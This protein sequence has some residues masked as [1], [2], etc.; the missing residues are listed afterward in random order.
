[1]GGCSGRVQWNL[2]S[3][4]GLRRIGWVVKSVFSQYGD[5]V[6][7]YA[8]AEHPRV[9][10]HVA[11]TIDDGLCRQAHDRSLVAEVR[12][13]LKQHKATATFF[14]CSDYLVGLEDAARGL[15]EDGNELANHCPEDRE[16]ASMPPGEF[17]EALLRTTQ[18][19]E[20]IPG[21]TARWFRAPQARLTTTM[22]AAVVRS[23]LRHALGDCYCDDWAIE[24]PWYIAS[25][26]AAQADH[27]SVVVLHMPERGFR[28]HCLEALK[29]VLENLSAEGYTCV[30]LSKL[31]EL[32]VDAPEP[33]PGING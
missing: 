17:E 18:A 26:I 25:T 6:C 19:I 3:T 32:S 22:R 31:D 9:R 4:V 27:G 23:G 15:L 24:N 7:Y 33:T 12:E 13:L 14:V 2:L 30:S 10:G 16:Y 21:G 28:E 20:A 5:T 1:M 29:L 8:V 11:L